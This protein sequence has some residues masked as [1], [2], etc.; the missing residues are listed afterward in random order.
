MNG[1]NWGEC[2]CEEDSLI[3]SEHAS[4]TRETTIKRKVPNT[5]RMRG[6]DERSQRERGKVRDK[7]DLG[8][9]IE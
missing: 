2:R 5:S 7:A 9:H 1:K 6:E 3:V 4:R 8:A